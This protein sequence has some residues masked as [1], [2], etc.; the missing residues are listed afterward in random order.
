MP[1]RIPRRRLSFDTASVLAIAGTAAISALGLRFRGARWPALLVLLC[2]LGVA[3][4][5]LA[6]PVSSHRLRACRDGARVGLAWIVV[7]WFVGGMFVPTPY[8]FLAVLLYVRAA[9]WFVLPPAVVLAANVLVLRRSAMRQ[10]ALGPAERGAWRIGTLFPLAYVVIGSTPSMFQWYA[11]YH[12]SRPPIDSAVLALRRLD[13]CVR[14]WTAANGGQP[15]ADVAA[16]GRS[17]PD[18]RMDI[19]T[20]GWSVGYAPNPSRPSAF[21]LVVRERVAPLKVYRS[22]FADEE[23]TIHATEGTRDATASD[24]FL[25]IV[26]AYLQHIAS[27]VDSVV[28]SRP[29]HELPTS[30][31]E[32]GPRAE[33]C[34]VLE[35]A[36]WPGDGSAIAAF[37]LNA[38]PSKTDERYRISYS[39]VTDSTGRVSPRLDARPLHSPE[40]GLRSYALIAA[41]VHGTAAARPA[42][43]DD[44]VVDPCEAYPSANCAI[45]AWVSFSAVRPER[46]PSSIAAVRVAGPARDSG[47][48]WRAPLGGAVHDSGSADASTASAVLAPPVPGRDG[49]VYA[50]SSGGVYAFDHDGNLRWARP[51]LGVG[52]EAGVA[53]IGAQLVVP[54]ADSGLLALDPENGA[55]RW[56]RRPIAGAMRYRPA[57]LPGGAIAITTSM[58]WLAVVERDGSLRF[59]YQLPTGSRFAA[60]PVADVGGAVYC[61]LSGK[62]RGMLVL[63]PDG[64]ARRLEWGAGYTRLLVLPDGT[65][66]VMDGGIQVV[67]AH[68]VPRRRLATRADGDGV[69]VRTNGTIVHLDRG[70]LIATAPNGRRLWSYRPAAFPFPDRGPIALD[71]GTIITADA[72]YLRGFSATGDSLWVIRHRA[73]GSISALAVAA[74]GTIYATDAGHQLLAMRAPQPSAGRR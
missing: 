53:L 59:D 13:G 37:S 10:L 24:A 69:L 17:G 20:S 45:A 33:A 47:I 52:G 21:S 5:L 8:I 71:D 15:P 66:A 29:G 2:T 34:D 65:V 50:A 55:T 54:T 16:L 56:Q 19:D 41:A 6:V 39:V 32:L 23:G 46:S 1:L 62:Q 63:G 57:G 42:D 43:A 12:P 74:D 40:S 7:I 3:S 35:Q 61:T 73:R 68:G 11:H 22:F 48:L 70:R 72:T 49:T 38:V 4:A 26:P 18:C 14:Q 67:D 60:A 25:S 27:C 51:E 28:A 30:L 64:R 36:A 44:P 9:P 31:A 58:G